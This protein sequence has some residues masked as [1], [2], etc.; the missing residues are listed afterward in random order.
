[1]TTINNSPIVCV[2]RVY[3]GARPAFTRVP[4]RGRLSDEW[5]H[6]GTIAISTIRA[7]LGVQKGRA[8]NL[9][10]NWEQL[11][12]GSAVMFTLS[13]VDFWDAN[14]DTFDAETGNA[15]KV[16]ESDK[17]ILKAD[18]DGGILGF[19]AGAYAG[20]CYASV[21]EGLKIGFFGL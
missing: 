1:M 14:A 18:R 15:A 8:I 4:V 5:F 17:R 2:L 10:T 16:Q 20:A 11:K 12:V 7:G 13:S 21:Y 19:F 9:S 6:A 3:P